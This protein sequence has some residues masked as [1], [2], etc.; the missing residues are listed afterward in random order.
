M[1]ECNANSI[2]IFVVKVKANFLSF[3]TSTSTYTI[4]HAILKW[5]KTTKPKHLLLACCMPI[6]KWLRFRYNRILDFIPA[7]VRILFTVFGWQR[8]RC[9]RIYNYFAFWVPSFLVANYAIERHK[10]DS[11]RTANGRTTHTH[12]L[13]VRLVFGVRFFFLSLLFYCFV[14]S[15]KMFVYFCIVENPLGSF[16]CSRFIFSSNCINLKLFMNVY[17]RPM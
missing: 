9:Q 12:I 4:T 16:A 13:W 3:S 1:Y 11:N 8:V 7:A 2:A 5:A 10:M 6:S 14:H 15:N 17:I